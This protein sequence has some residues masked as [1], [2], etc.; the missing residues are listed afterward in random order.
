MTAGV[1]FAK[2]DDNLIVLSNNELIL[3]D[4]DLNVIIRDKIKGANCNNMVY[5]QT[6]GLF[7]FC[8][9]A[10]NPTGQ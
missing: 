8:T 9:D 7:L 10:K 1:D 4:K 2:H 6:V 3:L 5:K